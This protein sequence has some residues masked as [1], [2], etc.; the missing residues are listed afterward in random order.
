MKHGSYCF[1]LD[2]INRSGCSIDPT[3]GLKNIQPRLSELLKL[4]SNC[5]YVLFNWNLLQTHATGKAI[6]RV[7][8][9]L[10]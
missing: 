4:I 9:S 6:K 5:C 2:L 10:L 1:Q 3:R 7:T 8:K